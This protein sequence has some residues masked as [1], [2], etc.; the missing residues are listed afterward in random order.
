MQLPEA[1]AL[2]LPSMGAFWGQPKTPPKCCA[3]IPLP[4]PEQALEQEYYL[5]GALGHRWAEC[6]GRVARGDC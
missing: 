2:R 6:G 3:S 4:H 1:A 5:V